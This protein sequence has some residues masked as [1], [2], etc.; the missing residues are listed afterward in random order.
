M[1]LRRMSLLFEYF[2]S[3]S[4]HLLHKPPHRVA[5]EAE[6]WKH[7]KDQAFV[8]GSA[9]LGD[10]IWP[11]PGLVGDNI[12]GILYKTPILSA[13]NRLVIRNFNREIY[14]ITFKFDES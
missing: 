14:L 1:I 11:L 8:P 12:I 13:K 6:A 2:F 10:Q 9:N 5:D 7:P 3:S 4:T